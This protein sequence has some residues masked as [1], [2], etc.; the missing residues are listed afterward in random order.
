MG[1]FLFPTLGC[2]FFNPHQ[3]KPLQRLVT[4]DRITQK[5]KKRKEIIPA[6]RIHPIY[7]RRQ[8]RRRG[9]FAFCLKS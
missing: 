4:I 8:A 3:A 7:P 1:R 2:F 6:S 5:K 9:F